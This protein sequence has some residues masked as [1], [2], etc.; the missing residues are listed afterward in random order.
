MRLIEFDDEN[1][2][3]AILDA[4]NKAIEAADHLTDMDAGAIEALRALAMKIDTEQL[5]NQIAIEYARENELKEP[6]RIDNISIPT[7]LRYCES[8][9][10][11]PV[12]RS[13]L[14]EKKDQANGN[15]KLAQL[16]AATGRK[17][18]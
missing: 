7:Y 10:L 17:P 5:I 6:A 14:E 2:S 4:T 3:N 8:L 13:K 15:S 18:A 12:G 16:R 9:G 1:N 11:T